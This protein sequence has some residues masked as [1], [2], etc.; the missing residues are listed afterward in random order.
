MAMIVEESVTDSQVILLDWISL[1]V[2]A[3]IYLCNT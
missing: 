2:E 1:K 3:S